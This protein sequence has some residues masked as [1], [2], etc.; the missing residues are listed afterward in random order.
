MNCDKQRLKRKNDFN[1]LLNK[2]SRRTRDRIVT[3]SYNTQRTGP[4]KQNQTNRNRQTE[5]D[6]QN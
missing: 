4:D 1:E 2:L 5:S 3:K 6:E